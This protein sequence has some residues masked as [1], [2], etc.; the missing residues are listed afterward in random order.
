MAEDLNSS[1]TMMGPV[2]DTTSQSTSVKPTQ[3]ALIPRIASKILG[4]RKPRRLGAVALR[5]MT[6]SLGHIEK[7][8]RR[9]MDCLP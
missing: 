6:A 7:G 8:Q 5:P 1:T 4:T 2:S 9:G 3:E